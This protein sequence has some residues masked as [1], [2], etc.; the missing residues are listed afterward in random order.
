MPDLWS[1]VQISGSSH[2]TS[3]SSSSFVDPK[4]IQEPGGGKERRSFEEKGVTIIINL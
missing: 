1:D 4:Q 2:Q 3:S